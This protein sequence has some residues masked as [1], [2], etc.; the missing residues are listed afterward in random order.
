MNAM[1]AVRFVDTPARSG[2]TGGT[3]GPYRAVTPPAAPAPTRRPSPLARWRPRGVPLTVRVQV[4]VA[5]L[6][7][8]PALALGSGPK[9]SPARAG[10][11]AFPAPAQPRPVQATSVTPGRTL[12][13]DFYAVRLD[14]LWAL[15]SPD[16]RAQW[17]TLEAFRAFRRDGLA[18]YGP[19][20]QVLQE[21]TF[22]RGRESVYVRSATFEKAP[23]LVW[24]VVIGFTGPQVTTFGITLQEDRSDDQVAWQRPPFP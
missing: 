1:D 12:L 11:A 23:A 3:G 21:R 4:V 2:G 7:L 16:V 14:G 24:A 8:T 10:A 18:Q 13:L 22:T 19:E 15:F 17:G 20:R 6:L 9:V 5:A